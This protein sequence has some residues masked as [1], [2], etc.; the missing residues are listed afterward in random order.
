M[1]TS[2]KFTCALL[3]ALRNLTIFIRIERSFLAIWSVCVFLHYVGVLA[4][5]FLTWSFKVS[6][7]LYLK[8]S[9]SFDT[10]F[11]MLFIQSRHASPVWSGSMFIWI[12]TPSSIKNEYLQWNEY[13]IYN[14]SIAHTKEVISIISNLNNTWKHTLNRKCSYFE[15]TLKSS[16]SDTRLSICIHIYYFSDTVT[17]NTAYAFHTSVV[18]V[19]IWT[20]Q[21]CNIN[22]HI[23]F[24]LT[25]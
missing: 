16:F 22:L 3:P 2:L 15:I 13:F 25:S 24:Q 19:Y 20:S 18:C 7:F 8:L 11:P 14:I 12:T 1:L 5:F 21:I 6:I 10:A 17:L 23:I 9:F 4:L